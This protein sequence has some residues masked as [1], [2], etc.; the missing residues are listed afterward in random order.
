M[1]NRAGPDT[2][3]DDWEP[4]MFPVIGDVSLE[5]REG[6]IW[7]LSTAMGT[8]ERVAES[9]DAFHQHLDTERA[10]EW[11]LP[12]LVDVLHDQSKVPGPG[13]CYAY[14]ILLSSASAVTGHQR[15]SHGGAGGH[16]P[17]GPGGHG[18]RI[19]AWSSDHADSVAPATRFILTIVLGCLGGLTGVTVGIV[20]VLI[21]ERLAGW[22][23]VLSPDA[24]LVAVGF[25]MAAGAVF[26][27][28]LAIHASTLDPIE[29]LR[30]EA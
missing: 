2:R 29:A 24:M 17:C 18:R 8:L 1:E 9:R 7:W 30:T 20:G 4:L 22:P 3:D 11:F 23:M 16:L 15:R 21:L 26:G 25:S 10:D 27:Y 13:Q 14:A 19:Q 28:Y 5:Q 12:G 6:T